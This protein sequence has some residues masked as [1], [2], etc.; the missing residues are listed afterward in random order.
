MSRHGSSTGR[1][2]LNKGIIIAVK[3]IE[4]EGDE[5]FVSERLPDGGENVREILDL[6][7]V[8]RSREIMF[9]EGRELGANLHVLLG[10]LRGEAARQRSPGGGGEDDHAP[11]PSV[12]VADR[13][14]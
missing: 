3:T 11:I 1:N 12:S 10:R 4:E 7:E 9:L 2:Y 6:V 5:F 8:R 13:I 14:A